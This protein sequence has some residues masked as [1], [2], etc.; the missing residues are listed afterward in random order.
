MDCC[1]ARAIVQNYKREPLTLVGEAIEL[2]KGEDRTYDD[3]AREVGVSHSTI[4]KYHRLSQLPDGIR[5]K[6]EQGELPVLHALQICRLKDE[7]DQWLLAFAIVDAGKEAL[8]AKESQRAVDD[9]R[10]SGEPM[11]DVLTRLF[12]FEFDR[13]VSLLLP[14]DYWLRFR[15]SR[16]AWNRQD[17]WKNLAYDILSQWLDGRAFSSTADLHEISVQLIKAATRLEELRE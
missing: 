10:R 6:V 12:G 5:W 9:V 7:N 4:S 2:L 11:A 16:A 17:E 8:T 3:V 14:V 15:I 13:T 1:G